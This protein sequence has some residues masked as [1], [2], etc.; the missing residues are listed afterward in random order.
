[1]GEMWCLTE[2]VIPRFGVNDSIDFWTAQGPEGTKKDFNFNDWA[3]E[4]KTSLAGNDPKIKISLIEQLEKVTSRLFFLLHV[5]I[6]LSE[7]NSGKSLQEFVDKLEDTDEIEEK[8]GAF[9][10]IKISELYGNATEEQLK[11]KIQISKN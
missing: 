9:F 2:Y 7:Q 11:K 6:N 10:V 8:N 5:M 4:I 1:M 3:L